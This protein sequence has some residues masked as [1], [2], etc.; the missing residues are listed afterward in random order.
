MGRNEG[1]HP[2]PAFRLG[3]SESSAERE[4]EREEAPVTWLSQVPPGRR[5]DGTFEDGYRCS[6]PS[7][8]L[9]DCS[10]AEPWH[11]AQSGAL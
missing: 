3:G 7:K 2:L 10:A 8:V 1:G 6:S 11:W 9:S 4:A 5:S